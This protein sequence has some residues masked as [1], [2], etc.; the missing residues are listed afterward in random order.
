MAAA[1]STTRVEVKKYTGKDLLESLQKCLAHKTSGNQTIASFDACVEF[2]VMVFNA[3]KSGGVEFTEDERKLFG[4]QLA[5]AASIFDDT[6]FTYMAYF[7]DDISLSPL[8][9]RSGLQ[10]LLEYYGDLPSDVD[11]GKTVRDTLMETFN[12]SEILKDLNELFYE[13]STF[14]VFASMDYVD[15]P[16]HKWKTAMEG[17]PDTHVWW[18]H[19]KL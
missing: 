17:L 3:H 7:M 19:Y 1:T 8:M 2:M 18:H 14:T 10:F 15:D 13:L 6:I 5:E 4:R 9:F 11:D 12:K 16:K